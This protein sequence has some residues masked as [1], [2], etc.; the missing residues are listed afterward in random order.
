MT[1]DEAM[2]KV[3][4][5]DPKARA[6]AEKFLMKNADYVAP[7]L[8]NAIIDE[9]ISIYSRVAYIHF[10]GKMKPE[11]GVPQIIALLGK[12][13]NDS[14]RDACK[15]SLIDYGSVSTPYLLKNLDTD[16]ITKSGFMIEVLLK[17]GR[18]AIPSLIKSAEDKNVRIRS[19]S[20]MV[21]SRIIMRESSPEASSQARKVL[22]DGIKD[23]D[24]EIRIYSVLALSKDKDN[25]AWSRVV[26][27]MKAEKAEGVLQAYKLAS[28]IHSSG[29]YVQTPI[30]MYLNGGDRNTSSIALS[31]LKEDKNKDSIEKAM[32]QTLDDTTKI[33]QGARALRYLSFA[34]DTLSVPITLKYVRSPHLVLRL[35][36]IDAYQERGKFF[37]KLNLFLDLLAE[38]GSDVSQT[39]K[40]K[41]PEAVG[42][43]KPLATDKVTIKDIQDRLK[44]Y[45]K[46]MIQIEH[47]RAAIPKER[48]KRLEETLDKGLKK[49]SP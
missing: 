7:M 16:R 42:K 18:V 5:L 15:I 38:S 30:D 22:L 41:K 46:D 12:T 25:T 4:S 19:G 35:A 2:L 32:K 29:D 11:E 6:D 21:L 24:D 44:E 48:G 31:L 9:E 43:G 8:I 20:Y 49:S 39:E 34:L 10:L 13:D 40:V 14:I 33:E 36:A 3:A 28:Q 37:D 27:A 45:L 1:V 17:Q 23:K 47:W 26:D